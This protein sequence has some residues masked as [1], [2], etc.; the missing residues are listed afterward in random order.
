MKLSTSERAVSLPLV[1][2]LT[3]ISFFM[4][5]LDAL[6][7]VTALPAIHRSVGGSIATLE[8]AVNAYALTFAAGII[9]CAALG[10]RLGRRRGPE[11][12]G[13]RGG[14]TDHVRAE[15]GNPGQA[16]RECLQYPAG[17]G[18]PGEGRDE[19]RVGQPDQRRVQAGARGRVVAHPFTAPATRPPARRRRTSRKK[20]M[21]GIVNSV[22]AAMIGPHWA[23]FL[24]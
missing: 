1:L 11:G 2:A 8:W 9:T 19:D 21:T 23:P 17:S 13:E 14:V 15:E 3:S 20:A 16:P 22:D 24:P 18:G 5:S 7:V 6:V 4:V 10:D 12:S